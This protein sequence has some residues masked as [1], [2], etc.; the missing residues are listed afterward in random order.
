MSPTELEQM[1]SEECDALK[2]MLIEK[3]RAYGSSATSPLRVFSKAPR[4]EQILVRMDDKLSRIARG[5]EAGEDSYRDL[6][7]YLILLFVTKRMETEEATL[8][9][10]TY[11]NR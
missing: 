10:T 4:T 8:G 3:H 9:Q 11:T 7:G 6:A 5:S 2:T 1:I